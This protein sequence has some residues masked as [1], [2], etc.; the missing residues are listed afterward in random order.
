MPVRPT[1]AAF[2]LCGGLQGAALGLFALAFASVTGTSFTSTGNTADSM[3]MSVLARAAAA[4]RHTRSPSAGSTRRYAPMVTAP[5][6]AAGSSSLAACR[7][8]VQLFADLHRHHA[9]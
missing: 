5:A 8:P 9:V 4:T 3:G 7:N 1:G 6:R 2:G